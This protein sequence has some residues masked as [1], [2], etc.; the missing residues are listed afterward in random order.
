MVTSLGMD[1]AAVEAWQKLEAKAKKLEKEL[2]SA[3]LAKPSALYHLLS[4][5]P[6]DQ[7]L[8]LLAKSSQRIVTDR[9]RN[10]LQKYL[11]AAQE[12][13]DRDVE[14]AGGVPGTPKF[15][16]LKEQMISKKLDARP[17]KIVEPALKRRWLPQ[18]AGAESAAARRFDFE[19]SPSP[20]QL[21]HGGDRP[22]GRCGKAYSGRGFPGLPPHNP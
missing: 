13:T 14:A 19:H 16:K 9:I 22:S 15:Q 12:V 18:T 11:P 6:G 20:R 17:K 1:K 3:K 8:F 5:V 7:M 21:R 2:Q 10:Y 4:K